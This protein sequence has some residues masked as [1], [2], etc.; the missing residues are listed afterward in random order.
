MCGCEHKLS[1]LQGLKPRQLAVLFRNNHFN[2][3]FKFEDAL[4]VLVTDQ[5]Y[6]HEQ[7]SQSSNCTSL[8]HTN[9]FM[10]VSACMGNFTALRGTYSTILHCLVS[11]RAV[12]QISALRF[13]LQNAVWEKLDTIDGNTVYVGSRI[14]QPGE[15]YRRVSN[16]LSVPLCALEGLLGY[17]L[18]SSRA[19]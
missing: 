3:L 16:L 14:N 11:A 1:W 7:A 15:H 17:A 8:Q 13:L 19:R 18:L 10:S 4:Y 5:G 9:S 6:L 12:V 2:T